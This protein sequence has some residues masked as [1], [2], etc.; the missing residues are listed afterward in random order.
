MDRRRH[1]RTEMESPAKFSWQS[2]G[3]SPDHQA[4]GKTRNISLG[5]VFVSTSDLPAVG[6]YIRLQVFFR[7][8]FPGSRLVLQT[9]AEVVRAEISTASSGFAATFE[10]Y[11][12]RNETEVLEQGGELPDVF[13]N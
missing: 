12:L 8:V 13:R 1:E 6:R 7:S 10:V 5:G 4:E 11:V 2:P 3:S 9:S